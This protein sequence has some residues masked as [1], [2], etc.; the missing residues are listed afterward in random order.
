[1]K[2]RNKEK[3]MNDESGNC[4]TTKHGHTLSPTE[5][6]EEPGLPLDTCATSLLEAFQKSLPS[7]EDEALKARVWARLQKSIFKEFN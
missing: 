6:K 2:K 5:G 4:G 1:M 7:E 3:P